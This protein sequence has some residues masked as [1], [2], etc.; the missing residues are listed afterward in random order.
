[1]TNN[2]FIGKAKTAIIRYYRDISFANLTMDDVFVVWSCKTLQNYKAIMA[3]N[4]HDQRI[5]E[6]TYNGD[7]HECYLDAY[8]KEENRIAWRDDE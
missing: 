7:K 4:A 6:V 5:F 1:M 3:T 2:I 8:V